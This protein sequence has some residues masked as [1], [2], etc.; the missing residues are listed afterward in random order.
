MNYIVFYLLVS[1]FL[2]FLTWKQENPKD[3]TL[4]SF[5]IVYFAGPIVFFAH[6]YF[7]Q[8]DV[9]GKALKAKMP[10]KLRFDWK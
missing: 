1:S 8:K 3:L 10:R 6:V 5:F 7:K 2:F 4:A 9:I